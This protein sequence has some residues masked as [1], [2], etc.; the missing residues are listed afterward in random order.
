MGRRT[1]RADAGVQLSSLPWRT[2]EEYAFLGYKCVLQNHVKLACRDF[3][4]RL[5]VYTD[6]SDVVWSII[7]TEVSFDDL[8]KPHVTPK[9]LRL[10]FMF[11]H[12]FVSQ[13]GWYTFE[14]EA[15]AIMATVDPMHWNLATSD[16][17]D[18][19]TDHHGL[20]FRFDPVAD[21]PN[22]SLTSFQKVIYWA[23]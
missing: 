15:Y 21:V 16:G 8:P 4:F 5:C 12:F 3:S 2:V 9:H 19:F 7:V 18:L 13:L 23:V 22:P 14:R 6:A 10:A 1:K 20:V 11:R 17:L